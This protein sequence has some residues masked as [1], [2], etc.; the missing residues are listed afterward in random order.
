M[1]KLKVL[2][3]GVTPEFK[4]IVNDIVD[5]NQ[6]E[7]IDQSTTEIPDATIV[8]TEFAKEPENNI[9]K[10]FLITKESKPIKI[11]EIIDW[12]SRVHV[13]R[14]VSEINIYDDVFLDIATCNL[15]NHANN[16]A[17]TLTEKEAKLAEALINPEMPGDR[18]S[19]LQNVWGY[20]ENIE[21][22]TLETHINRLRKKLEQIS[23]NKIT[24]TSTKNGYIL[25]FS[26]NR[27]IL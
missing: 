7:F 18:E 3:V 2:L 20:G 14:R 19:L 13:S 8:D 15:S 17:I 9:N 22:R 21:T 1:Q 4:A 25:E 10:A 11:A 24:V 12:L 5:K 23:D 16:A 6:V 26:E 27:N